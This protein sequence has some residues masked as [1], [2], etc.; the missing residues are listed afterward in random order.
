VINGPYI[1]VENVLSF[2]STATTSAAPKSRAEILV[3]SP[4]IKHKGRSKIALKRLVYQ[5]SRRAPLSTTARLCLITTE[6]IA[7][8]AELV[9]LKKRYPV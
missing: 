8:I 3:P 7:V 2:S 6:W 9:I 4:A 1:N 5:E